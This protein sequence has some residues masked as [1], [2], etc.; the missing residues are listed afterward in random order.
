[1]QIFYNHSE[2]RLRAGWRLFFQF[3]L[4]AGLTFVV[5]ILMSLIGISP[6]GSMQPIALL[7]AFTISVWVACRYFDKRKFVS[8][9]LEIDKR[10]IREYLFGFL[11]GAVIMG[12]IFTVELAVGWIEFTG[13][14][15]E[16]RLE[17][18][19]LLLFLG[20]FFAMVLVGFYEE[21]VFRG[22][23]ITN[24]IEGFT[25]NKLSHLKAA[26]LAVMISSTLFGVLHLLN[27]NASL[28]STVNIICAGVILAIPFLVIGSMAISIGLHTSWNFFQGSIFDFPVSGTVTQSSLLQMNEVGPDIITGGLFGPEAGLIGVMGILLIFL[29]F[30]TYCRTSNYP[31]TLHSSFK[32]GKR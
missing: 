7:L 3:L 11:M 24:M 12:I 25:G 32:T 26:L 19:Y 29:I 4:M 28:I 31:F 16:Q 22:Y 5:L 27:P 8:L 9:G 10:W 13:F 20:N 21:L 14:G 30:Y 6:A 23:Q 17:L 1:M 18:P 15:W 2:N